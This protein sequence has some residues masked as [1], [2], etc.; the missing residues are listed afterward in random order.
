MQKSDTLRDVGEWLR[1]G[2]QTGTGKVVTSSTLNNYRDGRRE[3]PRAMRRALAQQ[4]LKHA[5]R[6]RSIARGLEDASGD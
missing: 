3:M 5:D 6:L 4:L 2:S 1:S